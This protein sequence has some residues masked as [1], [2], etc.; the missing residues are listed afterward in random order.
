MRLS[1]ESSTA[2]SSFFKVVCFVWTEWYSEE[3]QLVSFEVPLVGREVQTQHLVLSKLD[4]F[5][6]FTISDYKKYVLKL[7]VSFVR[8]TVSNIGSS[9][10]LSLYYKA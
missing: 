3:L 8:T 10:F 1:L 6:P 4:F 5:F 9:L 7:I 2:S